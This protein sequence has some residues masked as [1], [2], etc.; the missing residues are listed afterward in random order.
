MSLSRSAVTSRTQSAASWSWWANDP[1]LIRD[2]SFRGR[3]PRRVCTAGAGCCVG[4]IARAQAAARGVRRSASGRVADPHSAATISRPRLVRIRLWSRGSP[5][6]LLECVEPE[7]PA[8]G[9]GLAVGGAVGAGFCVLGCEEVGEV[10][11]GGGVVRCGHVRS[12]PCFHHHV[13]KVSK[14]IG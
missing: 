3:D 10:L 5:S 13:N 12:K 11:G 1:F 2:S 4:G 8:G 9:D 6:A 14:E 7:Q